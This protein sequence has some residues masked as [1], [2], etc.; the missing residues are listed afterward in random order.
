[1]DRNERNPVEGCT[2]WSF[3]TFS[4]LTPIL[5]T[6]LDQPMRKAPPLPAA[7]NTLAHGTEYVRAIGDRD[8][9]LRTLT[10][11][12]RWPLA[13]LQLAAIMQHAI[14]LTSP[15]IMKR[16]LVFQEL[17]NKRTPSKGRSRRPL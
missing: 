8:T 3:L 1:M 15:L 9:V 10:W 16:I 13:I 6:G 17:N 4:W 14:G 5:Q 11:E 7:D 12:F 2:W